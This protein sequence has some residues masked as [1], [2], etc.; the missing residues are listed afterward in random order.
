MP[1]DDPYAKYLEPPTP[2]AS[3]SDPY[4]K[5]LTPPGGSDAAPNVGY[6]EALARTFAEGAGGGLADVALGAGGSVS[7]S[8]SLP[9]IA[10]QRAR[11]QAGEDLLPWYVRY[12]VEGLGIGAGFLSGAGEAGWAA[13]GAEMATA[14]A[15]ARGF[16]AKT[17]ARV[18]GAVKGAAETGTY[19]AVSGAAHSESA[20]PGTVLSNAATGGLTGMALGGTV[21]GLLTK[22]GVK[23]PPAAKSVE[24]LQGEMNDATSALKAKPVDSSKVVSTLA[25]V[26]SGLSASELTGLSDGFMGQVAKIKAAAQGG[27]LTAND[28]DSM[29]RQLR[30]AAKTPIDGAIAT[31]LSQ[32][33]GKNVM[34]DAGAADLQQTMLDAHARLQDAQA[35]QGWTASSAPGEALK[36]LDQY[37][38]KPDHGGLRLSDASVASLE[39]L[40]KYAKSGSDDAP[41]GLMKDLQQ[42]LTSNLGPKL[43]GSALG[44]VAGGP[45]GMVAVPAVEALGGVAYRQFY[46]NP[47]LQRLLNAA[48]TASSTGQAVS[49]SDYTSLFDKIGNAA[50]IQVP[51]AGRLPPD[52]AKKLTARNMAL[53]FIQSAGH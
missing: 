49:P 16:G 3:S 26:D 39:Q 38:N 7:G 18:G 35:M 25:D 32:S 6:G 52:F 40:T 44:Y 13:R 42:S 4:A 1:S 17:A 19:G 27:G 12:P 33:L 43:G 48:K 28:V 14:E 2:S 9:T 5:Y 20:D 24:E 10:S 34:E 53:K 36:M 23:T 11:T 29:Q 8:S 50:S 22:V 46:K 41:P 37:K 15:L 47:K 31:R 51:G 21:G 30:D 45:F